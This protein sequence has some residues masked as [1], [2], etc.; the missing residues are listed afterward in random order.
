MNEG[1]TSAAA[2]IRACGAAVFVDVSA[3]MELAWT[4]IANVTANLVREIYR[5]LPEHSYFF[6]RGVVIDPAALMTAI[7]EANGAYLEV[8]LEN[9]FAQL[10]SIG[11][12]S[13][14]AATTV[15]LFPNI[16][17]AHRFFDVEAVVFHDLSAMLMPEL[18]QGWA[19]HV[20][21]QALAR[22]GESSE[23]VC[24]VSEATA[25]DAKLYL[26]LAAERCVVAPLGVRPPPGE[27]PA[28]RMNYA[29]VLGTVEP[30]KNLRLVAEY[31]LNHGDLADRI[32]L[33]FVGRK[34]WGQSFDDVFG[35]L[36]TN[37]PWRE[38]I[39][40]TDFV[41][42]TDKWAL[43]RH[44]RFAIFP[45]LFEGFG[46]PV[47][48]AMAAGCPVITARSSSLVEFGLPDE[49]YFDPFSLSDFGRA[50]RH[51]ETMPKNTM[52][53]LGAAL[54]HQ[55]ARYGWAAFAGT[56]LDALAARLE[57]RERAALTP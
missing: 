45:S 25:A 8:L 21:T 19:A 29:V 23:V 37:S 28:Q 44:A 13:G 47:I 2:R 51:L 36:T 41:S 6:A 48:E 30:R 35:E 12:F 5:V 38:S 4:G 56:L 42:E 9:G 57:A 40:F 1:L 27:E 34:G 52:A 20:H 55:A 53:R 54:K 22:D 10:G 17:T 50:F 16:K 3:L 24:C 26:G 33:V 46:L 15:G 43:L 32:A 31:M 39:H 11:D 7:E 49:M 18:H 14:V